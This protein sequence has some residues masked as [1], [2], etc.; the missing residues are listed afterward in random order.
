MSLEALKRGHE[1]ASSLS[2]RARLVFGVLADEVRTPN[3]CPRWLPEPFRGRVCWPG[4][5]LLAEKS[6]YHTRTVERAL[7]EL[8]EKRIIRS[9]PRMRRNGR[10]RLSDIHEIFGPAFLPDDQWDNLG[11]LVRPASRGDQPDNPGGMVRDDQP[12]NVVRMVR[13]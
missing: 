1:I 6:G 2:P 11:R 7:E 5:K 3:K 8:R 4:E 13:A 12:D 10:G 9:Q